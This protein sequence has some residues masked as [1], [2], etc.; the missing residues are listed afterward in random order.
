MR[1]FLHA[2]NV[3]VQFLFIFALQASNR[4]YV[5][6]SRLGPISNSDNDND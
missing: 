2:E 4:C 5:V 1:I 3:L 6:L